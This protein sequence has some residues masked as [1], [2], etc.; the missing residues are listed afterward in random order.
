MEKAR[1]STSPARSF[2][3]RRTPAVNSGGGRAAAPRF[4]GPPGQPVEH[5]DREDDPGQQEVPQL[6][7]ADYL[8]YAYLIGSTISLA[9][10]LV[11][12]TSLLLL[13]RRAVRTKHGRHTIIQL[14]GTNVAFSF[15]NY[16]FLGDNAP[17]TD[18]IITHELVHI[19]QKH[20]ADVIFLELL[21]IINWFNPCIYLLQNSLK[22]I[23][24]YIADQHTVSHQ[25]DTHTYATFL[26]NTAHGVGGSPITHSFFNYNLLKK[27]IIMLNQKP[28]GKSARLKY[29]ITA[30][31]CAALLCMSTLAFTKDYNWID[32]DPAKAVAMVIKPLLQFPAPLKVQETVITSQPENQPAPVVEARSLKTKHKTVVTDST[33]ITAPST[34]DKIYLP[35][36][37]DG[38]YHAFAHYLHKSINY[39]PTAD[40]KGGAVVIGFTLDKSLK[41]T[42]LKI[43]HSAGDKLDNLAMDAFKNYK[44]TVNDDAGR[45]LEFTVYFFTD[46]YNIFKG[47][48]P[49]NGSAEGAILV[50]SAPYKFNVTAKGYEYCEI[51]YALPQFNGDKN[52]VWIFMKDGSYEYYLHDKMT[53]AQVAML[54]S[55]YGYEFPSNSYVAMVFLPVTSNN[56][57]KYT[58]TAMDV[59]SH[60]KAPYATAFYNHIYS[61]LKFPE[62]A[63]ATHKTSVVLIKFNLDQ[64]GTINN[65][66]VAK[67]GGAD[68]DAAAVDAVQSFNGTLND[69]AGQHT[70]AVVFCNALEAVKPV[71]SESFKNNTGYV[72]DVARAEVKSVF[73]NIKMNKPADSEKK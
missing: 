61:D 73:D 2:R 17:A 62:S 45:Y 69:N 71:V 6:G 8:W 40:D 59:N 43:V 21:K 60:L 32:L 42:D 22:T 46:D 9:V 68:F 14:P 49:G 7:V 57:N 19:R 1:A 48:E 33:S 63:K 66:G 53:D 20:S 34:S 26:V 28:S 70:V 65:V 10:L 51:P 3:A 4:P 44:G 56:T 15:F 47:K 25:T 64:N 54:K 72:G 52:Q 5:G 31:I 24:E 12:L 41:M 37:S 16:L 58:W 35:F 30:P 39:K 11:R 27:R 55:K 29:L 36:V 23:H 67:S 38:G 50:T 18:T 13:T